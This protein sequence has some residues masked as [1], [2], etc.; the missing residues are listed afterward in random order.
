MI[1][2]PTYYEDGDRYISMEKDGLFTGTDN[3]F[4]SGSGVDSFNV[5]G[6]YVSIG[7]K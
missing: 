3:V 1:G 4:L 2:E 6:K 7:G 5:T